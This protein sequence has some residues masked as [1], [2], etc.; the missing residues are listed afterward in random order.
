M[1]IRRILSILILP[2]IASVVSANLLQADETQIEEV[3][4]A[5]PENANNLQESG[6]RSEGGERSIKPGIN[7]RFLDPELDVSEWI[8]RFEIESREVYLARQRVLDAL[9]LKP[10]MR[11]ADVGAGTGFYSRLFSGA[12]GGSG[13]VYAVDISPRFLEHINEQSKTDQ[14]GN[15]TSVLCTDRSVKLPPKS[16]DAV[17]V[18]DT[19]HHFEY[20]QLTLASIRSALKPDGILNVIDFERIPGKSSDFIVG[21]VR[22]GKDV[23]QREIL[24]AGFELVEEV[25]I[26]SFREN[27]FLRFR[28]AES[29]DA[30]P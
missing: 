1:S 30:N 8:A 12:V 20:P 23:F 18:C 6:A 4:D 29:K 13:W 7:A 3:R 9:N 24:D 26:P 22:A 14:V 21:H 2:I 5:V 10:G 28:K 25:K 16:V 17:F 11:I 15:I 19:Y 27:Y